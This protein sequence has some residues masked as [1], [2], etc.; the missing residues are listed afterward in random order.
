MAQSEVK[1]GRGQVVAEFAHL[2][3]A[4]HRHLF[5]VHQVVDGLLVADIQ[6]QQAQSL[7]QRR[8]VLKG[9]VVY[10]ARDTLP[11]LLLYLHDV[12][13]VIARELLLVYRRLREHHEG[14]AQLLQLWDCLLYTSASPRFI[15][16]GCSIGFPNER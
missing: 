9:A 1:P 11:F 2:L 16:W 8:D 6:R 5:G 4:D 7:D 14:R 3:D 13:D 15:F 12:G 10:L